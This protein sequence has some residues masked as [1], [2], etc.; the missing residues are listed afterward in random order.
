MVSLINKKSASYYCQPI[1]V[2]SK[3]RGTNTHHWKYST[4]VDW[5]LTNRPEN[6]SKSGVLHLGVSDHS[7]I[8]GCRKIS[9]TREPAKMVHTRCLKKYKSAAFKNDLN[10]CLLMCDWTT[11]NPNAL[12]DQ[13]RNHAFNEVADMHAPFTV[14]FNKLYTLGF[15]IIFGNWQ[16]GGEIAN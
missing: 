13:F 9:F 8:Y 4:L 1:P 5:F 11:N 2:N 12:W 3:N 6:I 15:R 7:L 16:V 14:S 10:E